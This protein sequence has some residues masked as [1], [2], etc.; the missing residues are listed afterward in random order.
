MFYQKLI[1]YWNRTLVKSLVVLD[2][3]E[4]EVTER[5]VWKIVEKI[6]RWQTFSNAVLYLFSL[7]RIP[8]PLEIINLVQDWYKLVIR[9]KKL[10]KEDDSPGSS[11]LDSSEL[12]SV[13][14]GTSVFSSCWRSSN[15]FLPKKVNKDQ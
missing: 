3:C 7:C 15:E 1:K 11:D 14:S 10:R 8:L 9:L 6:L 2:Q 5:L 12:F 4:I 13:L